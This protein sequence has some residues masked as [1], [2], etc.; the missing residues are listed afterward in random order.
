MT[1]KEI[2]SSRATSL[3]E[4]DSELRFTLR[5]AQSASA[6]WNL[7]HSHSCGSAAGLRTSAVSGGLRLTHVRVRVPLVSCRPP[8]STRTSASNRSAPAERLTVLHELG[9]EVEEDDEAEDELCGGVV[10]RN[11]ES[12]CSGGCLALAKCSRGGSATASKV[13]RGQSFACRVRGGRC[14]SGVEN[15]MGPDISLLLLSSSR[16]A[17]KALATASVSAFASSF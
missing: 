16:V 13:L 4:G 1:Q 7:C 8:T 14:R 5:R 15:R 2:P 12:S 6:L 10:G 17:A 3:C 9:V 11:P